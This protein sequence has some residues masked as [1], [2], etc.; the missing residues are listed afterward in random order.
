MTWDWHDRR[1][2]LEDL[3]ITEERLLYIAELRRLL[4]EHWVAEL[5]RLAHLGSCGGKS[6]VYIGAASTDQR[7]PRDGG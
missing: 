6:M 7:R 2:A 4:K 3:G 5:E 1:R